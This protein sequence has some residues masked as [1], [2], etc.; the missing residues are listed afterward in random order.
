MQ[1]LDLGAGRNLHQGATHAPGGTPQLLAREKLRPTRPFRSS[2]ARKLAQH[3]AS[4][5]ISAKNFALHTPSHRMCGTKLA[6]HTPSHRMCGT[7]LALLAQNGRIW[8]ILP[9]HG[10][11]YTAV[12]SNKPRMANFLA[13]MAQPRGDD[14]TNDTS[15]TTD[16]GQR[17]TTITTA[18]P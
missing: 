7:K 5:G 6:L 2:T 18:R 3:G 8:R 14:A 4:T 10:E 13:H 17:E 11:L 1:A 16:T 9:A 12:A 15:T